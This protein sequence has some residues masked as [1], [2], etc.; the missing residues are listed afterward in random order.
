MSGTKKTGRKPVHDNAFKI[1]VARD[2]LTSSLGY[3]GIAV[4]YGLPSI[5]TARFFVRWYRKNYPDGIDSPTLDKEPDE[6]GDKALKQANLKITALEM[7]IEN[8]SKELGVDLA[9]KFGAKQSRK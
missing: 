2:Y 9:K 7:L 5:S 3:G 6:V 1:A 4:K 8:A